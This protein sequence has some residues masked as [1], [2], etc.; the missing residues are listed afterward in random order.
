MEQAGSVGPRRGCVAELTPAN[1]CKPSSKLA[2]NEER[3]RLS[4]AR[5]HEDA[6]DL[7]VVALTC[8]QAA[9]QK[10]S[11]LPHQLNPAQDDFLD[12]GWS[13]ILV[14][15]YSSIVAHAMKF[16]FARLGTRE[17]CWNHKVHM[18]CYE[19]VSL[20]TER[21]LT[22]LVCPYLNH[23]HGAWHVVGDSIH[24]VRKVFTLQQRDIRCS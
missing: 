2:I 1:S 7:S 8:L 13:G 10:S 9:S 5:K 11:R 22:L 6:H 4:L 3:S 16:F 18:T 20:I 23:L 19:S 21:R 12:Y 14:T 15:N 17:I 24:A